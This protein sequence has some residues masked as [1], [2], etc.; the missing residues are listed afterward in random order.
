MNVAVAVAGLQK[1]FNN[2]ALLNVFTAALVFALHFSFG[3]ALHL[4]VASVFIVFSSD[5]S[6]H[7]KEHGVDGLKDTGHELGI[8]ARLKGNE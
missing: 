4:A 7:I 1:A 3:N 2:F 8:V 5:S 6:K